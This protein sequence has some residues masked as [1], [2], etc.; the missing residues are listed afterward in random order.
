VHGGEL[1][2]ELRI[3]ELQAGLEELSADQQ[4]Q[5]A[6]HHQ[7]GKAEQKVKRTDVFVIGGEQPTTPPMRVIVS[8][9]VVACMAVVIKNCTH[10][11][12]FG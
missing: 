7:H 5:N 1:I 11:V 2:E 9:I 6:T 12:S 4:G 8:V 10:D 3:D